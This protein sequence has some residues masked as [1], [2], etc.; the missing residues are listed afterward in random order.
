M[1]VLVLFVW[2][3]QNMEQVKDP[4]KKNTFFC[5]VY[6]YCCYYFHCYYFVVLSMTLNCSIRH[7]DSVLGVVEWILHLDCGQRQKTNCSLGNARSFLSH[8]SAANLQET[9]FYKHYCNWF[10]SWVWQ[11]LPRCQCSFGWC[12]YRPKAA[13]TWFESMQQAGEGPGLGDRR[14]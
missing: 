8:S 11:K 2:H 6:Y 1:H 7:F 12:R 13:L 4:R 9:F 3:H 10:D 5:G 14:P